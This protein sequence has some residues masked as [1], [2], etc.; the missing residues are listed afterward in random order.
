MTS[1]SARTCGNEVCTNANLHK[2]YTPA[3]VRETGKT[4]SMVACSKTLR[5]SLNSFKVQSCLI[6]L[7]YIHQTKK[8]VGTIVGP[9]NNQI[10]HLW[11]GMALTAFQGFT[12]SVNAWCNE[13]SPRP[14]SFGVAKA[15]AKPQV[16]TASRATSEPG[17]SRGERHDLSIHLLQLSYCPSSPPARIGAWRRRGAMPFLRRKEKAA[18]WTSDKQAR[19]GNSEWHERPV[20]F[21][22]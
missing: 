6:W 5:L 15:T 8:H 14:L 1:L 17:A 19:Y 7:Q 4:N 11:I 18:Q 2:P 22:C 10:D 20:V 12:L 13:Y 3:I 9:Q 21:S 16:W